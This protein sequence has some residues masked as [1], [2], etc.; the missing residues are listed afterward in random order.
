M[1]KMDF[2]YQLTGPGLVKKS[3]DGNNELNVVSLDNLSSIQPC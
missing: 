2:S 3:P 1:G